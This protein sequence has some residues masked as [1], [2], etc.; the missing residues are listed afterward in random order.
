MVKK[1]STQGNIN[2]VIAVAKSLQLQKNL[3]A[4]MED[5]IAIIHQENTL[6]LVLYD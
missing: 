3:E 5:T 4:K 1:K 6:H 2:L